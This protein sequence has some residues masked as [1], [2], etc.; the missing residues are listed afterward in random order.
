MIYSALSTVCREMSGHRLK[1]RL[2]KI[3]LLLA[4]ILARLCQNI[5]Q[6]LV[7]LGKQAKLHTY[8]D[9][10]QLYASNVDPVTLESCIC[11]EERVTNDRYRSK[12]MIANETKH[13][14]I[15]LVL[16]KTGHS[17][18]SLKDSLN[19]FGIN[20]DNRLFFENYISTFC[21]KTNSQFNNYNT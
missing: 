13:Q 19:V 11:H 16:G 10:H 15:V 5:H 8:A 9:D 3:S 1:F 21:T 7:L 17:S 20:I 18:F 6:W 4:L 12:R 14:A 2:F